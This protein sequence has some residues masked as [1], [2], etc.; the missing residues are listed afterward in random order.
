MGRDVEEQLT[1]LIQ[2]Y[3][4]AK[5]TEISEKIFSEVA[6]LEGNNYKLSIR[7]TNYYFERIWKKCQ[8]DIFNGKTAVTLNKYRSCLEIVIHYEKSKNYRF[9]K[10]T[11]Y[12]FLGYCYLVN[13][14]LDLAFQMIHNGHMEN[15]I[16]YPKLGL[17]YKEAPS[18]LFMSLDAKNPRNYMLNHVLLMKEKIDFFII[19]HN[20]ISN[21]GSTCENFDNKFLRRT[22]NV[23]DDVKFFL[24]YLIMNL[25]NMNLPE[26]Q[27]LT[28]NYFSNIRKI[29]LIFDLSIV[30]DKTL[31]E[32]FKNK[33]ISGGVATL[34]HDLYN[35][36][37]KPNELIKL[38]SHSESKIFSFDDVPEL[39]TKGLLDAKILYNGKPIDYRFRCMLLTWRLRNF[40][41]HN[42]GGMN[43]IL[44]TSY[45]SVLVMLFSALF[46][47]TDTLNSN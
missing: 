41:A 46:F 24:V 7:L 44:S 36:E 17:D 31:F 30:I 14:N 42:L 20:K 25:I 4:V 43:Q 5:L 22:N 10:G 33:F 13:G 27:L 18:Y 26:E 47:A 23:F 8:M 11:P 16:V 28:N 32:R 6:H 40:S 21:I 45:T 39:V 19:E 3:E 37:E 34:L 12:L 35:A 38:L 15:L 2:R 1:G 9:H 29:E